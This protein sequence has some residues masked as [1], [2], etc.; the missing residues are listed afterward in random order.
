MR[1]TE[2]APT[3]S[4]RLTLAVVI[5]VYRDWGVV[6]MVCQGLDATLAAEPVDVRVLL[7][8]D[9]SPD[10]VRGWSRPTLTAL[11]SV[12]VLTL[13]RNIGHQRAI[14]VGLC[15]VRDHVACDAVLVMDAD[16]EDRPEDAARLVRQFIE[17]RCVVLFAMRRRRLESATFRTG[18]IVYRVLHRLLTG[19]PVRVGNFSV[20]RA[21]ILDRLVHMAELWNHYA[22]AIFRS[23]LPCGFL[24]TDRGP[25][26]GGSSHMNLI[27]LVSHGLAGI[28]SFSDVVA[29][30]ILVANLFGIVAVI[31]GILAVL[32][33]RLGTNASI[34]GWATYAG[35]L[36]L[37]LLVQLASVSFSLV[38]TLM[39]ARTRR[40][41]IPA[42]HYHPF[43]KGTTMLHGEA[44]AH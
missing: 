6:S 19:V 21:D 8:D 4:N 16:G 1:P 17:E 40:E 30:R 28:A 41:F 32:A 3:A 33:V 35:G 23:K 29:T 14:A 37:V 2:S 24:P 13:Q 7:V 42:I 27:A 18:Y 22:G 39:S 9:G 44:D 11:R 43:V 12:E 26:L 34:P 25:R 38:F 36:L 31:I 20:I 10:G 5:P 15:H